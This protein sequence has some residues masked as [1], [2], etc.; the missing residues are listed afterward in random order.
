MTKVMKKLACVL[1]AIMM[2]AVM[3]PAMAFAEEGEYGFTAYVNGKVAGSEVTLSWLKKNAEEPQIFAFASKQGEQWG[4]KVVEGADFELVL[5][6]ALGI[7][8]KELSD[9]TLINW[10]NN[11]VAEGK[12]DLKVSELKK[13]ISCFKLVDQNRNDVIGNFKGDEYVDVNVAKLEGAKDVTPVLS[14]KESVL[15]DTYEKAVAAKND[16]SWEE[17]AVGDVRL[18]VGGDLDGAPVKKGG[19]IKMGVPNFNGKYAVANCTN[20][21]IK[22]A[23]APKQVTGL[24]ATNVKTKSVKLTWTKVKNAEGYYVYKSTKKSSGFKKVATIKEGSTVK[25]TCKKLKKGKTYYFKVKAY[26]TYKNAED[27]VTTNAG[28]FSAVKS[29]KIKK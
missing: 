7:S 28:K 1:M 27:V 9:D 23:V 15:Y 8:F 19:E 16:G 26:N 10:G 29:A 3:M 21:L 25:Y 17:T 2:V 5:E 6:K 12:F 22:G 11:L 14:F 20:L 18:F 24:K 4:Y 13:A